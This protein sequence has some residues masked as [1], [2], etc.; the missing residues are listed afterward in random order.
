MTA[1]NI[2]WTKIA[3][4]S[5]RIDEILEDLFWLDDSISD[6][7]LVIG[8]SGDAPGA[9]L[10]GAVE[11]VQSLLEGLDVEAL[12]ESIEKLEE[13]LEG[14]D[15]DE[16]TEAIENMEVTLGTPE[17]T[18]AD[19]TLFGMINEIETY[20]RLIGG[21]TDET[22][23]ETLFGRIKQ[24]KNYASDA[25]N[26][27]LAVRE[28]LGAEGSEGD[29]YTLIEKLSVTMGTMREELNNLLP[30][31]IDSGK[32][33]KTI[34]DAMVNAVN[35]AAE[36]LGLKM[37]AIEGLAEGESG[38]QSGIKNKLEEIK[39]MLDILSKAKE[40]DA[41]VIRSWFEVE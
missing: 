28:E 21:V 34:I 13:T 4:V 7:R 11:E 22:T 29:V 36:S 26:E 17:D 20:A 14:F 9:S 40:Q 19:N 3:T 6:L 8:Q 18:I 12:E 23:A 35:E 10:Y 1:A 37:D 25:Y 39:A 30:E 41:V 38:D 24:S 16:L 15:V 5:E 31:Q 32:M 2:D 27:I 33:Q